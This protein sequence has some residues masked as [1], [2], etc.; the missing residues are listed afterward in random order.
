MMNLWVESGYKQYTISGWGKQ[1]KIPCSAAFT[2]EIRYE[3]FLNVENSPLMQTVIGGIMK[4]A[5]KT[6]P[7]AHELQGVI[8]YDDP[9]GLRPRSL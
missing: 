8:R 4:E 9:S 3:T 7:N 5:T 2:V 6:F 1:G